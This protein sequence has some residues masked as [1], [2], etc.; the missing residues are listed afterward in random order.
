MYFFF[1]ESIAELWFSELQDAAGAKRL[2]GI[3][4]TLVMKEKVISGY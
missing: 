2:V 3:H 1:T 4:D